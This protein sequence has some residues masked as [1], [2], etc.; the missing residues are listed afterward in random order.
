M[1]AIVALLRGINVGK[2]KRLAMADLRRITHDIGGRDVATLLNS[3][4]LVA[5]I[6]G[7]SAPEFA[8]RLKSAIRNELGIDVPVIAKWAGEF[9][10]VLE[11]NPFATNLADPTRL[12][13]AF[14]QARP[15][16]AELEGLTSSG[17]P[18]EELV[19]GRHAAFLHVPAGLLESK[20]GPALLATKGVTT[21]NWATCLKIGNLLSERTG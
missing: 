15:D 5:A 14:T 20:I 3:G 13:V 18:P 6:D 10:D 16:L 12:L 21:R 1:S 2:A 7:K 4:N 8:T 17:A 9:T 19:V 11:E